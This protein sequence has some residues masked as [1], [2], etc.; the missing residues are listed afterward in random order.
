MQYGQRALS[1]NVHAKYPAKRKRAMKYYYSIARKLNK[2][3][4]GGIEI[5]PDI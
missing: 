1:P 2:Y 5:V 4:T 3:R